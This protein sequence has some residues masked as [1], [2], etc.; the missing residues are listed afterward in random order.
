[1]CEPNPC[2]HGGECTTITSSQF[3]CDCSS[4]GYQGTTCE[5]GVINIPDYPTLT[6]GIP[7]KSIEFRAS[8]PD[9]SVTFTPRGLGVEFNPPY[10]VFQRNVTT[11]QSLTITAQQPGLL[12]VHY[13]L[14]GPSAASFRTPERNTFFV[15]S[16]ENGAPNI[17]YDNEDFSFASGCYK[18]Q[19]NKC[20][21]SHETIT[22]YSTSPW[23]MFGPTAITEDQV[24]LSTGN[25]E[26]LHSMSGIS[27]WP[28]K[29]S[30]L[31][32]DCAVDSSITYS[33]AE[34]VKRRA[35]T[36]SFLKVLR[37]NLPKWLDVK[38]RGNL[39]SNSMVHQARYLTGKSLREEAVF[40]GQPLTEDTFFSLLIS[41]DLDV[42]VHGDRVAFGLQDRSARISVAME[43]CDPP[44]SNV[45]L[46]PSSGTV[47]VM[48]KLSVMKQLRDHGWKFKIDSLQVSRG[49][50]EK[51]S[52]TMFATFSKDLD[53]SDAVKS[54]VNFEGTI[55]VNVD[56]LN[57][58]RNLNDCLI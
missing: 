37:N 57:N 12:Y 30:S 51:R 53:I 43:L 28:E 40:E 7:T 31:N 23:F 56:N 4:T 10:L 20:P 6:A 5:T 52:L 15:E 39:P 45:I 54:R 19:L 38:L 25:V 48:N 14:S 47:D 46:R 42:F 35:L 33:T 9:N 27:F 2:R 44:P 21:R 36:K 29:R 13:Y 49:S 1:M 17:T 32:H 11:S 55:I 24:S 16:A 34:L 26:L 18:L 8:P 58:V 3:S 41:P 22:A 50:F